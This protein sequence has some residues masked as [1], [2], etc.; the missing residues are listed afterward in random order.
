MFDYF[1][2]T[3]SSEMSTRFIIFCIIFII[4]M[5]FLLSAFLSV[6]YEIVKEDRKKNGL[7]LWHVLLY[8]IFGPFY[9]YFW[10][11]YKI[12]LPIW[13]QVKAILNIKIKD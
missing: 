3:K 12:H 6:P 11:M 7:K 1:T 2:T 13:V 4:Y 9:L 5:L 8:A 10:T